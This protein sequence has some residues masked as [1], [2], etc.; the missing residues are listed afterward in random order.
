MENINK[1]E[2]KLRRELGLGSVIFFIF[3]YVV[4]AGILIQTGAVAGQ[5]GPSLWLAFIIAGIPNVI[6]AIITCYV[7]SAFPVSGGSWVYSSR[8]GS[9]L[10]GFL[11]LSS[12]ILHIMGALAL[13]AVGFATYFEIFIPGSF[14]IAA[15]LSILVFYVINLFGIKFAGWVQV[16]LSILGDLLV[17]LIFIIFGLPHVDLNKLIGVGTGGM[18]PTGFIGIFIGAIIL[19]FSYAGFCCVRSATHKNTFPCVQMG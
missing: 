9:P 7:V 11:V 4:G 18:F 5:V 6:Y 1:N 16:V 15:I 14:Y 17:I 3:G 8:L 10:I 13:L 12:I 2:G 19:S